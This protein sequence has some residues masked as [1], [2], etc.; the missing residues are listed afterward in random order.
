M[1]NIFND[2]HPEGHQSGSVTSL[3]L[4]RVLVKRST[5][6]SLFRLLKLKFCLIKAYR[7]MKEYIN[8]IKLL[9]KLHNLN[10]E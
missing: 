2:L 1:L 6:I 8:L 10:I 5:R 3:A 9:K 4:S 7:N